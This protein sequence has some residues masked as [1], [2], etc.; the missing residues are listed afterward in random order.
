MPSTRRHAPDEERLKRGNV[1]EESYADRKGEKDEER[2]ASMGVL[3]EGWEGH[4]PVKAQK[5][6]SIYDVH[7]NHVFDPP[8]LS[9]CV[10]MVRTPSPLWTSTHGR[11]EIHTKKSR[12]LEMA[13]TVTYRT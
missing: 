7:K 1:M 6:P 11:H 9:T 4:V 13:S 5:G 3:G 12:S 8:P 2:K 10:H